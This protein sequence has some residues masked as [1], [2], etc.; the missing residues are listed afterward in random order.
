MSDIEQGPV[1]NDR[2]PTR[3][4]KK[5]HKKTHMKRA[6]GHMTCDTWYMTCDM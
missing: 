4:D 2:P 6:M 1:D 5:T 3:S